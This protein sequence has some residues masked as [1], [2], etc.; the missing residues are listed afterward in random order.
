[1]GEEQ[2]YSWTEKVFPVRRILPFPDG[3]RLLVV[4]AD[5]VSSLEGV[6]A[7]DVDLSRRSAVDLG[8]IPAEPT[9]VTWAEPGKTL[10][11]NRTVTGLTNI[12]KYSLN[13]KA[14]TQVTLGTGPDSSPMLD[15]GGKGI[16]FVN[17][18]LSGFL[19]VYDVHSKESRDIAQNATQPVISRDGKHVMYIT[20]AARDRTELWVSNIDGTNKVKIATG[21]SLA[22]GFWAPN[23][24]HIA[25]IE[26]VTGVADKPYVAGAD[27]SGVRSLQW[28]GGS[29]QSVLW[30]QDQKS[31]FL[32]VF[33]KGAGGGTIW[34][35]NIESST[36][37]KVA[38]GCGFAFD[39][40]PD[41][42]YLLNLV[43]GGEGAGIYEFSLSD[44]KCTSLL[45]GVVTFGLVFAPDGKSF[46]Y[47]VPSRHDVTIYR[48]GWQDG[49]LIGQP[50]VALKL[51]FAFP[52]LA[53]GNAYDFTRNLSDVVY[54]RVGGH[55]DLY[56]MSQK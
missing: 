17:G 36:P 48:Q 22:T 1:M 53:G 3:N 56:L 7:F 45:P 33:E 50:Q 5:T 52:L 38:D 14:L 34:R 44:K 10:V 29:I 12:W 32:N 43:G 41:G 37:E 27:G 28:T 2:V 49:K 46:M 40:A 42:Q 47:A 31:V 54:A 20:I 26:E 13:D 16:Y 39:A 23:N 55:A 21:T 6:T 8:V 30:S 35:E 24:S 9:S 51:P 15:P 19:T 11:F 18:R 4:T 25:F